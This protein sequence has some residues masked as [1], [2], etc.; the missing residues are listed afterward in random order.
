MSRPRVIC[1]V[2]STASGK[3]ALGL[4]LA[5]ALGGEIVSADSRQVYRHLEIGTAKPSADERARVR[6]H[7]LDL[8]D[9]EET[10]DAARFR[11]A[12]AEAI[13]DV[14][15]RGRVPVVVGGTG[16]YVRALLGGLCAAPARVPALREALVRIARAEGA[17][18]LHRRLAV[19]DPASASRIAPADAVR[20]VRALE[21]A[22]STG[23][24]LSE[25]QA[26]HGFR[27]APYD[28]LVLGL[29]RPA[30]ELAA[31]IDAR[32]RAMM[33]AGLLDEVRALGAR[34]PAEAP[35]FR[36]VGYREM[37]ACVAGE[38]D[39]AAALAA[40]VRATRRFAK[41]QRTWFR[42][43]AAVVWRHP[44]RDRTR[45]VAEATAFLSGGARPG[46]APA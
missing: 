9:P 35:A 17:P 25:W 22:L 28:V 43:E 31:R 4:E 42:A 29:D 6:H 44:D 41:R 46:A 12:A 39:L 32:A 36:A 37:L 30:D 13:A 21:V 23:R 45:L 33:A 15:R 19:L 2:G 10:F 27:E 20:S 1:V 8:V 26:A 24:R 5:T 16:L 11:A 40:M 14:D 38:R 18:A 7:C 3:T 34:I